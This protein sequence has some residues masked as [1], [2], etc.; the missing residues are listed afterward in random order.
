MF[1]YGFVLLYTENTDLSTD[2]KSTQY[3]AWVLEAYIKYKGAEQR[4]K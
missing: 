4:Y 1:P 2:T 3:L